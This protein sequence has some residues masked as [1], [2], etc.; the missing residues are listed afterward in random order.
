MYFDLTDQEVS[1]FLAGHRF[2]S[3]S[4]AM[5][6]VRFTYSSRGH[7]AALG[8]PDSRSGICHGYW[9]YA[10]EVEEI[11]NQVSSSGPY[12]L[13]LIKE[14]SERWAVCDDWGDLQR[15]WVL[16]VPEG[17]QVDGYVGQAKF[18]PKISHEGQQRTARTTDNSYAGGSV[19][20]VLGLSAEQKQWIRGPIPTLSLSAKKLRQASRPR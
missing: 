1:S 5:P 4:G 14:I 16:N 18:Q 2:T 8:T 3:I 15:A 20:F 17:K 19:Q 11:L 12:G 13:R 10:D 9:M 7:S 6:F